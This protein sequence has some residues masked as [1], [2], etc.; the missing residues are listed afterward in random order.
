MVVLL[1]GGLTALVIVISR[2]AQRRRQGALAIAANLLGGQVTENHSF[3]EGSRDGLRTR[4]ALTSRGAGSSSESWT[5]VEC[6]VGPGARRLELHLRRTEHADPTRIRR[7]ELADVELGAADFDGLFII[8]GA[9]TDVVKAFFDPATR[10]AL[11]E[12]KECEV[13]VPITLASMRPFDR[14]PGE[15]ERM[16]LR[17]SVRGWLET[18]S[19]IQGALLLTALLA[20]RVRAALDSAEAAVPLEHKGSPYRPAPDDAARKDARARRERELADLRDLRQRRLRSN[21]PLVLLGI[22][23]A[24]VIGYLV[25]A[26]MLTR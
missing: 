13:D 21:A 1:L 6:E 15:P 8:E 2:A 5:E 18:E 25:L 4:F 16:W 22:G 10:Q 26:A 9:P 12:W 20:R 3:A 14:P 7:G 23:L 11:L 17:L 24:F 19:R